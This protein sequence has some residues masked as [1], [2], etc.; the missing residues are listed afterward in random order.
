[1]P[2]T[3]RVGEYVIMHDGTEAVAFRHGVRVAAGRLDYVRRVISQG[4]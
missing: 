4:V 1:M 2:F 3:Q